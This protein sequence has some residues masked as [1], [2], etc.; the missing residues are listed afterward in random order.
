MD[1]MN[2]TENHTNSAPTQMIIAI[3]G[4]HMVS[5]SVSQTWR[6]MGSGLESAL[7]VD[8]HLHV[9]RWALHHHEYLEWV[10]TSRHKTNGII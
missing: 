9:Q 7:G 8:C 2:P 3:R 6:P 5:V 4:G 10:T 1:G